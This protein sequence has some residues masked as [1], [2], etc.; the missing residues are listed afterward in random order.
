MSFPKKKP[1]LHYGIISTLAIKQVFDCS[2]KC[3]Y[4]SGIEQQQEFVKGDPRKLFFDK[5]FEKNEQQSI[6]QPKAVAANTLRPVGSMR[7]RE[8]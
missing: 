8:I 7:Q 1:Q 4:R 6:I 2:R 5:V 3:G